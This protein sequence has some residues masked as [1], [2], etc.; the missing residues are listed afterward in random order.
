V[1][2]LR[3]SFADPR[4]RHRGVSHHT[5]AVVKASGA[6]VAW[7]AGWEA[8][9]WLTAVREVDT[10]GWREACSGLPLSHMGRGPDDD[11]TFFEAA[12]AAGTLARTYVA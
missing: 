5:R 6:P 9:A 4:E 7:P 3:V 12:F 11:P 8:P 1:A 2:A 10:S